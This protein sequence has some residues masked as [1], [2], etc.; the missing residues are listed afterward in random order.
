MID[1]VTIETRWLRE[2]LDELHRLHLAISAEVAKSEKQRMDAIAAKKRAARQPTVARS[3]APT[4]S[5]TRRKATVS[6]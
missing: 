3:Q 5:K 6:T 1:R 4:T 2:L